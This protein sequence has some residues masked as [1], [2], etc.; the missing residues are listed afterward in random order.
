MN[1]K[2]SLKNKYYTPNLKLILARFPDFW[3][4]TSHSCPLITDSSA[5]AISEKLQKVFA[6]Y[7]NAK[8]EHLK[9]KDAEQ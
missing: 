7:G 2:D 6:I 5:S 3:L 1:P 8:V 4:L 9:T